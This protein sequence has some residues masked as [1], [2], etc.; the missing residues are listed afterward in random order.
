MIVSVL[1]LAASGASG[2]LKTNESAALQLQRRLMREH[3][4]GGHSYVLRGFPDE[5]HD[6]AIALTQS[7]TAADRFLE[8]F[9]AAA[10]G[11]APAV[12]D[13]FKLL[14]EGARSGPGE[15]EPP[16]AAFGGEPLLQEKLRRQLDAEFGVDVGASA[17]RGSY[18]HHGR[19]GDSRA[20]PGPTP[21]SLR[22]ARG[23][24]RLALEG[25]PLHRVRG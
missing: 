16:S 18:Y 23:C 20:G 2:P 24:E 15:L 11:A 14:L 5:E 22:R 8:R 25:P 1:H 17:D 21:A 12:H 3:Q 9:E 10:R 6:V 13:L 19:E 4:A 7:D